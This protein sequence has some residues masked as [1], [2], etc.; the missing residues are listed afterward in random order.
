MLDAQQRPDA[1]TSASD[2][3]FLRRAKPSWPRQLL[4]FM[5]QYPLGGIGGLI[6]VILVVV[7]VFASV[8]SPHHYAAVDFANRLNAPDGQFWFGTD[9]LGRDVFSRVV[10]GSR[11]SLYVGLL[12]VTLGTV[13]GVIL[14]VSSGYVGGR[15][16]LAVQRVVDML[17]GFPS[18]VLALVMI[19]A[20][21]PS[22][23]SVTFA[24]SLS[25]M[26]RM[27]RLSR[28]TALTIKEEVYVLATKAIGSS[29]PRILLRHVMPNGLAPVF[30]LATSA[31]GSAIVTE[32]S[33]SFLG[34]GVPPPHTSW[35]GMLQLGAVE[36]LESAPWLAIFPGLALSIVVFAFALFGDALRDALDPR[37]RGSR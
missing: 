12:S 18:L 25:L 28:S 10:F 1:A 5:V 27:T 13:V 29:T 19:V 23:N 32:A 11:T 2:A 4:S 14:G 7:A 36:T 30:V 26:P 35:G 9:K 3:V 16:D 37:L 24:I 17:M 31:L 20:L 15:F 22:L 8:I 6:L 33:L 21:S 34:L